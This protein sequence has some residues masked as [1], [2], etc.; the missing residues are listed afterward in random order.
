M[1]SVKRSKNRIRKAVSSLLV[2]LLVI[3]GLGNSAFADQT[4]FGRGQTVNVKIMSYNIHHA[5][6]E[7]GI[8]DL[9]RIARIIE[10]ED[11]DIVALQ[12]VDNHWSERSD[13]QDQAKWLAESLGMFYTYAANLDREPLNNGGERRQYGTAI[14]SE[15]PIIESENH[16]LS[17]IGNTE[18]RGLLEAT[19]N[20]SGNH[21]NVYNTHLA[22]TPA[23]RELQIKEIVEI[24]S[25][26]K[27][28]KVILGDLNATP[29]S[30][31]M[32][33][34]YANYLDVFAGP[35]D[36]NTY[37]AQNPAKRID[38]IFTSKNIETADVEVIKSLASDHLPITADLVLDRDQPYY[39]GNK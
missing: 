15:Y 13:F 6:G 2:L 23:E 8:L 7:D 21:L 25:Q 24:A 26:S 39:N 27:G 20:I 17:Q 29:E 10:E 9:E 38:Y 28:P 12:E 31:E 4:S 36:A 1:K 22:L 19:I 11:T 35:P 34:M 3:L 37:P 33:P 16:F 5:E 18:Q 30:N 32:K 14:L